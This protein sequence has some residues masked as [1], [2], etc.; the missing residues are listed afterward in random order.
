MPAVCVQFVG[1]ALL[2]LGAP[3]IGQHIL[4]RPAGI[5]EL[6]PVIKILVLTADIKEAVDR[7]RSA[8]HLLPRG[9][10]PLRL[11]NSGSRFRGIEPI[12]FADSRTACRSR[13]ECG[14]R[15]CGRGRRPRQQST[16][17]PGGGEPVGKH[18]A[19]QAGAD[20]DVVVRI[21]LGLC[22]HRVPP[23][24]ARLHHQIGRLIN[25][26][27]APMRDVRPRRAVRL[28][29]AVIDRLHSRDAAR[30]QNRRAA[31]RAET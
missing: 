21:R 10:M 25:D 24:K 4:E 3:E 17:A 16:V 8:Q 12:H 1:P 22:R 5:A 2:I 20:D 29:L 23:R 26:H 30:S 11:F 14:S 6:P 27:G 18:A 9:W 13:A 19:G 15:Y 28:A 31:G 7:A